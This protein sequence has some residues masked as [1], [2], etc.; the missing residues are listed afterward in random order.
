MAQFM[1]FALWYTI[2]T[3]IYSPHCTTIGA[4]LSY[5]ALFPKAP[6]ALTIIV[7]YVLYWCQQSRRGRVCC[8]V[9]YCGKIF[10]QFIVIVAN[11]GTDNHTPCCTWT[12]AV[13]ASTYWNWSKRNSALP[14]PIIPTVST[15]VVLEEKVSERQHCRTYRSSYLLTQGCW[16]NDFSSGY[17]Y[18]TIATPMLLRILHCAVLSICVGEVICKSSWSSKWKW[19]GICLH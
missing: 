12:D 19:H 5:N 17:Y 15:W 6:V 13:S 3:A 1:F 4:P 9:R 18:H 8:N 11:P 2:M 16:I 7:A 10:V 14:A